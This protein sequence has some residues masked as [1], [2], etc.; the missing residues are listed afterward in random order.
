VGMVVE[1]G[2]REVVAAVSSMVVVVG[3]DELAW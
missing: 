3:S 1:Q 2:G